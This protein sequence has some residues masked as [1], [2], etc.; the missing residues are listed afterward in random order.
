MEFVRIRWLNCGKRARMDVGTQIDY[1]KGA[2]AYANRYIRRTMKLDNSLRSRLLYLSAAAWDKFHSNA[3]RL[4]Y[5][6]C[7]CK[8]IRITYV[9]SLYTRNVCTEYIWFWRRDLQ[10][11]ETRKFFFRASFS[12][13]TSATMS[14]QRRDEKKR[15]KARSVFSAVMMLVIGDNKL[16][17]W[18][19]ISSNETVSTYTR[20]ARGGNSIRFTAQQNGLLSGDI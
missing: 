2:A 8:F 13:T 7:K 11:F 18:L 17:N 19:S 15:A 9:C 1:I 3:R 6:F 10:E 14:S 12:Y 4:L 16:A 20:Y 5:K